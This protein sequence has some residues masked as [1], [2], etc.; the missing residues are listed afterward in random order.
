MKKESRTEPTFDA[1]QSCPYKMEGKSAINPFNEET[2]IRRNVPDVSDEQLL[3]TLGVIA[4]C[5]REHINCDTLLDNLAPFLTRRQNIILDLDKGGKRGI[6]P[7]D[8]CSPS[9]ANVHHLKE[10]E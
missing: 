1:W 3:S 5:K 4:E 6:V 9:T 2:P 10:K 7:A 8:S